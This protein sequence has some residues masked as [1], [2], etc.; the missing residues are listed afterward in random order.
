MV[1]EV[2]HQTDLLSFISI[3]LW[4]LCYHQNPSSHEHQIKWCEVI[5]TY[6]VE[7]GLL[8]IDVSDML[9]V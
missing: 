5:S 2:K 8:A 7:R 4:Y 9:G 3:I 1:P 6:L